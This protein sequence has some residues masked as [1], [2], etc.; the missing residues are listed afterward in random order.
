ML[1]NFFVEV[2]KSEQYDETV[3]IIIVTNNI[4][5]YHKSA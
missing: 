2:I 3:G 4:M 1:K 5:M